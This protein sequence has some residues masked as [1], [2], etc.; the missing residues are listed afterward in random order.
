MNTELE[1]LHD[2]IK[3]HPFR[4]KNNIINAK[5]YG[6]KLKVLLDLFYEEAK[7]TIPI[8]ALGYFMH[9]AWSTRFH[10]DEGA[11]SYTKWYKDGDQMDKDIIIATEF[12]I[13]DVHKFIK[14]VPITELHTYYTGSNCEHTRKGRLIIKDNE[15]K[16]IKGW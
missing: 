15:V 2:E 6:N 16:H 3:N 10:F 1:T 4:L 9:E 12:I 8:E 14:G 5:S 13:S 7:K 11:T